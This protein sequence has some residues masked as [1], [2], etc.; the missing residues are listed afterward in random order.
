MSKNNRPDVVHRRH[1]SID[2]PSRPGRMLTGD[3]VWQGY[4]VRHPRYKELLLS[5]MQTND[6]TGDRNSWIM[7]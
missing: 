4:L 5:G 6:M 1:R 3:E 7:V 2:M